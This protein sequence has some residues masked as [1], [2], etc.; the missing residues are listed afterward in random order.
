M[1]EL[2]KVYSNQF[3]TSGVSELRYDKSEILV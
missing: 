2:R 3:Q 1:Y